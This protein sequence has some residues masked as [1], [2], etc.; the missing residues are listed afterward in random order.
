MVKTADLSQTISK[1]LVWLLVV[2]PIAVTP[3]M[4]VDPI[5]LIKLVSL[6]CG[7]F[8]IGA[9]LFFNSRSYLASEHR[10]TLSLSAL[11]LLQLTLVFVFSG[12]DKTFQFFGTMGRNTGL[13]QYFCPWSQKT[14]MSYLRLKTQ[15]LK[16]IA[17]VRVLKATRLDDAQMPSSSLS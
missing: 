3:W 11:L 1:V 4:T 6:T 17:G 2:T 15:R 14:E 9:L 10:L 16:S 13:S 5:N 7:A 12:V 8:G